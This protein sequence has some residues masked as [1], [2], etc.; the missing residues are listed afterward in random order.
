MLVVPAGALSTSVGIAPDAHIFA[1]SKADW[2]RNL[3]DIPSLD[4]LP[5]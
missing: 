2:D 4:G 5:T 3:S 1:A